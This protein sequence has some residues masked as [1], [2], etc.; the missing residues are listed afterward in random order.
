MTRLSSYPWHICGVGAIGSLWASALNAR[1]SKVTLLLRDADQLTQYQAAG[2][3]NL[4]EDDQKVHSQPNA[5]IP[6]TP[7]HEPIK[8]MLVC[9]KSYAT[10]GA[11]IALAETLGR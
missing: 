11:S 2:G 9:C 3:I 5:L 4:L 10:I 8:H 1:G 6:D 7:P